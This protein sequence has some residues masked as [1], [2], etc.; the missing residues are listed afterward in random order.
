MRNAMP[1]PL[2]LPECAISQPSPERDD[3][4]RFAEWTALPARLR[5]T[6][7]GTVTVIARDH[8]SVRPADGAGGAGGAPTKVT[9]MRTYRGRAVTVEP[10]AGGAPRFRLELL[11]PEHDRSVPLAAGRCAEAISR[12]WKAWGRALSLPLIAVGRDG[13]VHA[14]LRPLG[15][16]TAETPLPR[17]K[18][19]PLVGRRSRFS[20]RRRTLAAAEARIHRDEREIIARN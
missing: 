12:E 17:R 3:L 11:H 10:A 8:V 15:A 4:E 1:L 18:G 13:V 7:A 16:L 20:R 5:A 19:S 14:A 6:E 9:P 2:P